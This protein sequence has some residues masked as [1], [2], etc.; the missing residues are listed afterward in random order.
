MND[1]R[2]KDE[3][4]ARLEA[5]IRENKEAIAE[6]ESKLRDE[7]SVRRTL[8]NTIQELKGN[9]R[10]FCRV[11]PVLRDE[12]SEPLSVFNF[13]QDERVLSIEQSAPG[14]VMIY[15]INNVLG[16][17]PLENQLVNTSLLKCLHM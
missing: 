10:V 17:R 3:A 2:I 16:D 14:E 1:N 4:I 11:R 6:L 8:H 7:E 12:G 13:G 9:I 5:T 15:C